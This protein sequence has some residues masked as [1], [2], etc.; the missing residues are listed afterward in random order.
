MYLC[1]IIDLFNREV[2]GW[3]FDDNMETPLLIKAFENAVMLVSLVR[4]VFFILIEECNIQ[5]RI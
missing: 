5:V 3:H 4:I 1:V 2:I